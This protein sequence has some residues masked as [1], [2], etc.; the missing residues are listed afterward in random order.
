MV[1]PRKTTL[2]GFLRAPKKNGPVTTPTVV[3]INI[4]ASWVGWEHPLV[5]HPPGHLQGLRVP[6]K[7]VHVARWSFIWNMSYDIN[8]DWETPARPIKGIPLYGGAHPNLTDSR[9]YFANLKSLFFEQFLLQPFLPNSNP[10]TLPWKSHNLFSGLHFGLQTIT[11]NS[12]ARTFQ[13][14]GT[15]C[16][17]ICQGCGGKGRGRHGT[18]PSRCGRS[19]RGCSQRLVEEVF[20]PMGKG[21]W[22]ATAATASFE[23]FAEHRLVRTS[24]T[25]LKLL[26]PMSIGALIA[27]A[28]VT[29]LEVLAQN[30]SWKLVPVAPGESTFQGEV[31]CHVSVVLT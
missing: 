6:K 16:N 18:R 9:E 20:L 29:K 28:A 27:F 14:Q 31:L 15:L 12:A 2:L 10:G 26:N 8:P 19:R 13:L 4:S 1:N 3:P 5:H 17:R 21:T 25:G 23:K 24:L 7:R 30:R 11:K 22:S